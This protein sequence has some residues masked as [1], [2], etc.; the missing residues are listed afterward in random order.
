MEW[1]DG[2]SPGGTIRFPVFPGYVD[3]VSMQLPYETVGRL[4]VTTVVEKAVVR[5]SS[6]TV[7]NLLVRDAVPTPSPT[8]EG[9]APSPEDEE[10]EQIN[11]QL[12]TLTTSRRNETRK[13]KRVREP[14][15]Q[16]TPTAPAVHDD[17]D[18]SGLTV[19][20][21]VMAKGLSPAGQRLW[22]QATITGFR[23]PPAWPPI[24]V[25]FSATED[26]NTLNLLLPQPNTA[27]VHRGDV[28]PRPA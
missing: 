16:N 18:V 26:G 4:H 28:R 14:T 21:E 20:E 22:Y 19:G 15:P 10:V 6:F 9:D 24:V 1:M 7:R 25:K 8:D 17:F 13:S 11:E 23:P 3:G 5:G 2:F 12:S 27:Y